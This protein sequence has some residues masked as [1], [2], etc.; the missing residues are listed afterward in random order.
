V[1]F[2]QYPESLSHGFVVSLIGSHSA[3]SFHR[4]QL[5]TSPVQEPYERESKLTLFLRLPFAYCCLSGCLELFPTLIWVSLENVALE[6][7]SAYTDQPPTWL[8][9]E[10]CDPS[11]LVPDSPLWVSLRL[12]ASDKKDQP[13]PPDHLENFLSWVD[14]IKTIPLALSKMSLECIVGSQNYRGYVLFKRDPRMTVQPCIYIHFS[15]IYHILCL[16]WAFAVYQIKSNQIFISPTA[17]EV[18]YTVDIV[19]YI[20]NKHNVDGYT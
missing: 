4:L 18:L 19:L 8:S 11:G 3:S 10:P 20:F 16:I 1:L 9:W 2:N 15:L 12:L 5:W 6:P 14:S 17:T 7:A 13:L